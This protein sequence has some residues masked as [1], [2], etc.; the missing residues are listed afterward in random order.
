M[1]YLVLARR[2]RPKRFDELV[3]QPHVA[4]TLLNGLRQGRIAHAYLFTGPRGVGKTTTARLVARALNCHNPDK[5]ESCGK[6]EPCIAISEGRFIDAIEIDAASNT[7][8]DDIRGLREGIRYAP[9]E[10][11]VKIYVI[12]EAHMLSISAFNALLK[13]LEEPPAHAYFCLATTEPQK[14]PATI[15]SR[16]QR[17][18]FRRISDTELRNHIRMICEKDNIEFDEEALDTIAR[19]ADGSV[20]DSLSLLDQVIAFTGGNVFKQDTIEVVGEVRLDQFYKAVG[21]V[22]SGSTADAFRLDDTLASTG[23]DPHDYILG[24][25]RYLVHLIQAKTSGIEKV[26]IP[27]EAHDDFEQALEQLSEG[28]LVRLLQLTTTAETDLRRNYSPRVRLQLLMLRFAT[29]ERSLVLSDLLK[30]VSGTVPITQQRASGQSTTAEHQRISGKVEAKTSVLIS[31]TSLKSKSATDI[32]KN[33]QITTPD[34]PLQVAQNAWKSVCSKIAE[35]HN[36][37]GRM[38]EYGGYPVE[39]S[40]GRLKI[41][42]S[43]T[44]LLETARGCQQILLK[45]MQAILGPVSL[46]LQVGELPTKPDD[47]VSDSDPAVQ[48]LSDRLG[49]QV[50]Y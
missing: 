43:S 15:I 40:N 24:L 39:Y 28:D 10:G 35:Q 6:C 48:L 36:S 27:I 22:N 13:T 5:G 49:A 30:Q 2:W 47:A 34:N 7:G 41:H 26:D 38:M 33:V 42:F 16:C 25:E 23:T 11:K 31:P 29:F 12:D 44:T 46:N 45:E 14:L 37:R 3:G 20:R 9:I 19:K 1:S 4:K 21:L 32:G 50:I 17:F 8:V 18:D